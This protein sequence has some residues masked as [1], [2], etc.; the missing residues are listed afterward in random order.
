[1]ILYRPSASNQSGLTCIIFFKNKCGETNVQS[2]VGQTRQCGR[3]NGNDQL[4]RPH[5]L[6]RRPVKG[7]PQNTTG[8]QANLF[9]VEN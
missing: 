6:F 1:M 3:I 5:G 2:V 4:H 8:D 9:L 7:Q